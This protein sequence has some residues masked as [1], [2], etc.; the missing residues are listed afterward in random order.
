MLLRLDVVDRLTVN[1]A[2]L[3]DNVLHV[4]WGFATGPGSWACK[5]QVL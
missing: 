4:G 3:K 2:P 5:L 1:S